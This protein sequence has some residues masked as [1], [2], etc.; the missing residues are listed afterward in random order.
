MA[1]DTILLKAEAKKLGV[2]GYRQMTPEE[3]SAAIKSA[4]GT[5]SAPAKGSAAKGST[6]GATKG[7]AAKGSPAKGSAKGSA[8][9]GSAAKGSS[10]PAKSTK[11]ATKAAST[12]GTA[13]R[14][15]ASK[16]SAK[17]STAKGTTKPAAR[18]T[19][20]PA[21]R[22]PAAKKGTTANGFRAELADNIDWKA[23]SNVGRTGKRAEVLAA[24]R[25]HKGDKE[26]A[27]YTLADRAKK[28]YPAKTKNDAERMLVWLI[29]RVAYD[30]AMSTGQHEPGERAGYGKSKKATDV[31]RRELRAEQAA[32]AQKAARKRK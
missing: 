24:L 20:K 22:K 10:A 25:K 18:K 28:F 27:F 7:S 16:G 31:R 19:A 1:T 11:P 4:K 14:Q 26:K 17:A 2:E 5:G 9:K 21:A 12:K 13:K 23:E 30:F 32:E 15:T 6:N 8:A 3:L 29:G